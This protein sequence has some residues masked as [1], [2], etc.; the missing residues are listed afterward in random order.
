MENTIF[1][2]LDLGGLNARITTDQFNDAMTVI[3]SLV[4]PLVRDS[5]GLS[6][7]GFTGRS[8]TVFYVDPATGSDNNSGETWEDAFATVARAKASLGPVLAVDTYINLAAG[9]YTD[10][11]VDFDGVQLADGKSL[12]IVGRT[13]APTLTTGPTAVSA[14]YVTASS[15]TTIVVDYTAGGFAAWTDD[16][17]IGKILNIPG[18]L[19][20]QTV[21]IISNVD[22]G[23]SVTI[24]LPPYL[25]GS[26]P[27]TSD[28]T[29]TEPTTIFTSTG[30]KTVKGI[31]DGDSANYKLKNIHLLA[32]MTIEG[33]SLIDCTTEAASVVNFTDGCFFS[34]C[35][36]TAA[37]GAAAVYASYALYSA[38]INMNKDI[39]SSLA[40]YCSG[41]TWGS[42]L[43]CTTGPGTVLMT[44][45]ILANED[46]TNAI[47]STDAEKPVSLITLDEVIITGA[48]SATISDAAVLEFD[49]VTVDGSFT[50]VV[51][52]EN[53]IFRAIDWTFSAG[54][55]VADAY[56]VELVTAGK[57]FFSGT[58]A[59]VGTTGAWRINAGGTNAA[60]WASCTT[61]ADAC[62]AQG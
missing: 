10:H 19:G 29:I 12:N 27:T 26:W 3:D 23:T 20:T 56:A 47:L 7:A 9:T 48:S 62:L 34:N 37:S 6:E 18:A 16:E 8:T 58:T 21:P 11:T 32:G 2:G 40:V 51:V 55:A 28:I 4:G 44:K 36:I 22:G 61:T 15:G 35:Y 33:F 5:G 31:K 39:T 46:I 1:L 49:E 25:V 50:H 54:A 45:T 38:F 14:T 13:A 42:G 43:S 57:V 24:T 17:L 41:G 53:S 30:T 60:T 52:S 59:V